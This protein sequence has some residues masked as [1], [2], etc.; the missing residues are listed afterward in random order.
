[1]SQLIYRTPEPEIAVRTRSILLETET[2]CVLY[3]GYSSVQPA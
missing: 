3:V 2:L 1:M